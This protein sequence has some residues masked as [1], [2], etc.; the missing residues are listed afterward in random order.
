[1]NYSKGIYSD[2]KWLSKKYND[3]KLSLRE[4][5]KICH[6]DFRTIDY[7]VHKFNFTRH[8]VG[9]RRAERSPHWRGG[10]Y[11]E[12]GY[13]RINQGR[14]NGYK[15]EHRIVAEKILGRELSTR[16]VIH[17]INFIRSDNRPENLYLFPSNKDHKRYEQLFSS[18]K[19][20]LLISNLQ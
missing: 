3:E 17:H 14:E 15:L 9:D 19:A 18:G 12:H 4:I 13:R 20:T 7:W 16:E 5:S 8:L 6:T 1:M 2:K 10:L 11:I